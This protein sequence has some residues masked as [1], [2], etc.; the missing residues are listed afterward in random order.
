MP[1]NWP[2]AGRVAP[3]RITSS[4]AGTIFGEM[5]LV[6]KGHPRSASVIADE[7][8]SVFEL[9][10]NGF[11]SILETNPKIAVKLLKHFAQEM[12]RRLRISDSDLRHSDSVV[13]HRE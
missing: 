6:E 11:D 4:T 13:F 9:T 12:A 7:D 1:F 10:R 3:R 5:A 8:I 2:S